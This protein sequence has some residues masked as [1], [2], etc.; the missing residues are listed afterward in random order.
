MICANFFDEFFKDEVINEYD[1]Y[2]E[3]V[4]CDDECSCITCLNNYYSNL[5]Q[6]QKG[7]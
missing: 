3:S 7:Q 1:Y 2:D 6:G 4:S 5:D